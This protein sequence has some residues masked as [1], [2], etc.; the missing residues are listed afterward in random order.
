VKSKKKDK[1]NNLQCNTVEGQDLWKRCD[2]MRT[3][4]SGRIDAF[5]QEWVPYG[6]VDLALSLCLPFPCLFLFLSL[7]M[8]SHSKKAL[9]RLWALDLEFS[10]FQNHESTKFLLI[11]NYPA[12]GILL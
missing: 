11:I 4:P 8:L 5:S 3:P 6:K 2:I 1:R 9:T 7:I 12:C 10:S